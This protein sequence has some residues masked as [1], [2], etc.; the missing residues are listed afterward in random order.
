MARLSV[1][2]DAVRRKKL[3]E[4]AAVRG[5]SISELVRCL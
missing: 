5:M 4:L 3:E 1:R 2:L